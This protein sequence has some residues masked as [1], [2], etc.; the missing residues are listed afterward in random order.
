MSSSA[1]TRPLPEEPL[2]ESALLAHRLAREHCQVE[3][4]SRESCAWYHG[5]WLFMRLLGIAKTS[6]GHVDFLATE[7]SKAARSATFMRVL[8]TGAA[9]YSMAGCALS[10]YR[11]EGAEL[12][13]SMVDRCD[14]PLALTRWYGARHGA[15]VK[16]YC[17]DILDFESPQKFD[18]VMTNSFLGYFEPPARAKLFARWAGLLRPGG[19]LLITNRIR[20]GVGHSPVGFTA[21]QAS[22][23]TDAVRREASRLPAP[24]LEPGELAR[25]AQAYAGRFRS[26]PL[27]STAEIVA[28]LEGNGFVVGRLDTATTGSRPRENLLTGPTLAEATNYVRVVATRS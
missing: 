27:R 14:T 7:L 16:T 25:M 21:H 9:D 11:R 24:P 19:R 1:A 5:F 20:P 17:A 8:I 23:F 26:V 15:S 10:A 4:A 2:E 12:G 18:L 13:L 6:G 3:A 22:A 28:L